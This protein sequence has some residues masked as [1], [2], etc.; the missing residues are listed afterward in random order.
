MSLQALRNRFESF[1]QFPLLKQI[2]IFFKDKTRKV[3]CQVFQMDF[4]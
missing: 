4:T 1:D 3:I 2:E